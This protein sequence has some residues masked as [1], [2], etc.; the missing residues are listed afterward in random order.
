MDHHD[1]NCWLYPGEEPCPY[2]EVRFEEEVPET[3]TVTLCSC[4]ERHAFMMPGQLPGK[5]PRCQGYL[6]TVEHRAWK[7][8]LT[9][10][11]VDA[12]SIV[13][14]LD[15][16]IRLLREQERMTLGRLD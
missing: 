3:T 10:Q 9:G 14:P 15:E 13:V 8:A 6:S 4:A 11:E 16:V 7:N 2:C 12:C 5:C 1:C